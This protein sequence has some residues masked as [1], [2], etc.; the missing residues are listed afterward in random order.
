M[1]CFLFDAP[2]GRVANELRRLCGL[3]AYSG[4]RGD[5]G[6]YSD[7]VEYGDSTLRQK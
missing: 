4:G 6:D 2:T 5:D 1:W 3:A 7:D